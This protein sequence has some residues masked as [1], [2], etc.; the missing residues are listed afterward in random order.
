MPNWCE[1][2]MKIRG[3]FSNVV[4]CLQNSF[5]GLKHGDDYVMVEAPENIKIYSEYIDSGE[6]EIRFNKTVY[7]KHSQRAFVSGSCDVCAQDKDSQT[8]AIIEIKQAWGIVAENYVEMS[9][10]Y[11]VDI[12][13]QAFERGMEFYQDVIIEKGEI[14]RDQTTKYQDWAWDCPVPDFGG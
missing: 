8:T 6:F 5:E 4:S 11:N 7:V 2:R 3:K 14:A 1:G 12:R 9:R 13:I 10:D